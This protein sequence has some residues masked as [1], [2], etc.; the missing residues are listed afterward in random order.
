MKLFELK[1][2]AIKFL[3]SQKIGIAILIPFES[4]PPNLL[5]A[6]LTNSR[7]SNK[8]HESGIPPLNEL[9]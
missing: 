6:M 5:N 4:F 7:F 9:F 1:S 8:L 2:S 3:D